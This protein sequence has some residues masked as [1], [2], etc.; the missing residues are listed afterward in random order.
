[1]PLINNRR[2]ALNSPQALSRELFHFGP[3]HADDLT[4]VLSIVVAAFAALEFLI[5]LWRDANRKASPHARG[6]R[7]TS[8][9]LF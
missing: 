3:L 7:A 9:T 5:G 8:P 4:L 1:M 2:D 6:G